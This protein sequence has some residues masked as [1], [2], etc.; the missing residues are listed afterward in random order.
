MA[1]VNRSLDNS[2]Q[3]KVISSN[4]GV[5]A[6]GVT[7]ALAHIQSP[8]T[9]KAV[10]VAGFG[11]SG[12]PIGIMTI[13]RFIVGAGLTVITLGTTF[14]ARVFGT[15]GVLDAGVSLPAVGSTL[16]NLLPNDVICAT[17]SG[18]NAALMTMTANFLV[19]P[20]QDIR[21]YFAGLA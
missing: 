2:E 4:F 11:A 8:C 18:S 10:Q 17:V 6:T 12:S 21:T 14:G 9:L 16:L 1:I 13:Q 19:Q 3:Y 7:L 20:T 5:V 15:S